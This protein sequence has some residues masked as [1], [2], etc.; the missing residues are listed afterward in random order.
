MSVLN[1]FYGIFIFTLT[2]LL[3]ILISVDH[4]S[5]VDFETGIHC[6]SVKMIKAAFNVPSWS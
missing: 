6:T 3:L 1:P 2:V 4:P 5:T